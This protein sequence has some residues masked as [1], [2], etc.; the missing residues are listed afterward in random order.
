MSKE[1]RLGR[2]LEALLGKVAAFEE[3]HS[4]PFDSDDPERRLQESFQSYP[5]SHVDVM[6]ID[7]NPYQPRMDFDPAELDALS[8][9]ITAHGL[10]QPI[11]VRP[12]GER[13][14]IIAGERRFRAAVRAGW[15]EVPVHVLNAD[16]RQMAELALTENLQRK[17]LNPLEKAAAFARYI[18]TYG[19]T[20]EELAARLELNRTTV[21]NF[22]RLLDLPETIQTMLCKEELNYT[23][24]RALLP[25]QE[26]WERI[27]FARRI[28]SEGWSVRQ[29]EQAVKEYLESGNPG[30]Q[31]AQGWNII[32]KNGNRQPIAKSEYLLE[33]EQEFRHHLGTKVKLTQTDKGKGKLV[34]PFHSH[35]EFERIYKWICKHSKFKDAG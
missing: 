12:H 9:S 13:Y 34:I 8:A 27:E 33:L 18:E 2:G 4:I 17:D 31:S 21:I 20:C 6:Q 10:L 22:I 23:H 3:N 26:E 28:V 11:V 19:G 32:D 30:Q 7:R 15:S 14:Q 1:K 29:T 35:E 25:L 5:P 24:A 16:D